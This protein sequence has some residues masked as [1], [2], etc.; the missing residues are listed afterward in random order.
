[1][2]HR[3]LALHGPA[4]LLQVGVPELVGAR[5][6]LEGALVEQVALYGAGLRLGL[7]VA[8]PRLERVRVPRDLLYV[9]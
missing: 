6:E 9:V 7:Q 8:Q 4:A 2:R 5:Q 3:H 1:M